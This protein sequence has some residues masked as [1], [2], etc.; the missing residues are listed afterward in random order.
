MLESFDVRCG[1]GCGERGECARGIGARDAC[2]ELVLINFFEC[3]GN[4]ARV[5]AVERSELGTKTD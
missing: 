1:C 4:E 2:G 5:C 3:S